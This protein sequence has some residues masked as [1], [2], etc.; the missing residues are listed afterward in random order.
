MKKT[1]Y[2]FL[3]AMFFIQ[4]SYASD[5]SLAPPDGGSSSGCSFTVMGETI[6][7][8]KIWCSTTM[9]MS[10]CGLGDAQSQKCS[11]SSYC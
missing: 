6:P 1:F 2:L 3:S 11:S 4:L 10:A 9:S 8:T 5:E 7:C